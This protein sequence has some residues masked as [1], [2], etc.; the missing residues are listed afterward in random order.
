MPMVQVPLLRRA[1][2]VEAGL[3][4]APASEQPELG[5][6]VR[7]AA[8]DYLRVGGSISGATR[9]DRGAVRER[10]GHYESTPTLFGDGFFGAEWGGFFVRYGVLAGAGY[11]RRRLSAR[12]CITSS[13]AVACVPHEDQRLRDAA[14]VRTY[15]QLHIA[16][17]PPGPLMTSFAVR[18]PVVVDLPDENLRR[19]TDL[20]TEF[21]LTQ[22]LQLRYLRVDLQPQWSSIR[23]FAFHVAFLFRFAPPAPPRRVSYRP[24]DQLFDEP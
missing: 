5:G 13:E 18:V 14:F 15:G 17:A 10:G 12:G 3:V 1:G 19:H 16:L 23:G 2:Q 24:K 22:T 4:V 11:G 7:V 8:T 6:A 9:H 20:D 21:A